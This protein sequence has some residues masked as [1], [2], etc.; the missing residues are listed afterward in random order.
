MSGRKSENLALLEKRY[1][2]IT[3]IIEEKKEQLLKKENI[4]VI[5]EQ[6]FTGERILKVYLEKEKRTLYLGGKRNPCMPVVNQFN[7]LGKIEQSAPVFVIGMG[8][9]LYLEEL[10]KRVHNDTMICLYEPCFSIFY[11]QL[12]EIDFTPLFEKGIIVLMIGG[13]NAE[14]SNFT[15]IIEMMLQGNR[16]PIMKNL[17]IPN[18]DSICEKQVLEFTKILADNVKR[19]EFDKGTA[20][21]FSGVQA[22]NILNNAKYVRI[23]YQADQLTEVI[24]RDIPAIVVAAGPSLNKNIKQLKKAKNKAF[25]IAVDTAIKPLLKEDIVPDMFATLDGKKP[26]KLV[27]IEESRKIPL[28]ATE[29]ASKI[30]LEY[31]QG[32][33]FF[34]EENLNYI[35][36]M[37]E[38]NDKVFAALPYGGS[39]ATLAFSL[40]CHLGF[41][42]IVMV[43]QDLAYTGN[44]S[45]AD[46]TFQ[47]KMEEKDTSNYIMV[48]GNYEEQVPTLANL[49]EYRKWFEEFIKDWKEKYQ[50][51][52]INATEGGAKIEGTELMTLEEVIEKECT[53]EVNI[54]SC[55]DKL[56]PVFNSEEQQ[57]I[58]DYFHNTPKEFQKIIELTKEGK[59][60]Y[61]KLDKMCNNHNFDKNAY[62]KLLRRIKKNTK[63]IEREPNYQMISATLV[64]AN[65]ILESGQYMEYQSF[66]EEGKMIAQRGMLFLKLI[67][68]CA[69]L[70]KHL[71]EETV[72]KIQ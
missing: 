55:I 4:Q 9:E 15:T 25:I 58:L 41:Q 27:S 59:R 37:Y 18:Y 30:L 5:T 69:E 35:N 1:P 44:K 50:V 16:I 19:Y 38:I 61:Q 32:K 29:D 17:M 42:C 20:R 48:P 51:R 68:E 21:L 36:R 46:G 28:L 54:A 49:N 57:K 12:E 10:E 39:V 11:H 34:F 26:L 7:L 22:D 40:V 33:K 45:H 60:L 14:T 2:G 65:Q 64:N 56:Q 66:E 47:E 53:K 13:I 71:S 72:A 62:V 67:G 24:P 52:F 31:H 3:A 43:G 70:L 8:N 6:A 63:K 23:G